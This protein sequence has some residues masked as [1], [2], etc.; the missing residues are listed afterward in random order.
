ME[1][2]VSEPKVHNKHAGTAPRDAVYIGRG[3]AWGNPFKIG[4]DGDRDQVCKRFECEILPRLDVSVLRGRHLVCFCKPA[5][6]HGDSIL[7]KANAQE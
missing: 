6:C 5:R 7:R 4:V 1:K 3:S 2:Q